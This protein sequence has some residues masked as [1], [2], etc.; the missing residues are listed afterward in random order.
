M[1]DTT[2]DA[3]DDEQAT[4]TPET[5]DATHPPRRLRRDDAEQ[6]EADEEQTDGGE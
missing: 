1:S 6:G 5:G 3:T 2:D 4:Q